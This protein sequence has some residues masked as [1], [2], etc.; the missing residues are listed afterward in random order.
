M[1]NALIPT[2]TVTGLAFGGLLGGAV[3]TETIFNWPGMGRFAAQ[4]VLGFDF[5][6]VMGFTILV[7]IIYVVANLIVDVLYA[8]IDPRVRLGGG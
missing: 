6:S 7:A 8:V 4:A 1:R 3:L 2:V 5:N